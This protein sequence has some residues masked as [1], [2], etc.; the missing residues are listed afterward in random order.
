[1]DTLINRIKK[2][3]GFRVKPYRCS[4]GKLTVGYGRNLDDKGISAE[5][6]ELMLLHDVNESSDAAS[7]FTWFRRLDNVRQGV[8][9]EMI[10]NLGL[11]RFLGFKKMIQALRD[12]DYQEASIQMM[13][14]KWAR[15]VKG[16]AIMLANIMTD[17]DE[18]IGAE[19]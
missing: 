5:E 8:I 1:M 7:Q 13:D 12:E 17:N 3:E 6:A 18:D 16:R 2:H 9:I 14:S 10:F 19:S 15:Q 11:P 4:A